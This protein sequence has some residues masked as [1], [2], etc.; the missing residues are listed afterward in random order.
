M[1][2][3]SFF[4][5]VSYEIRILLFIFSAIIKRQLYL[6][7]YQNVLCNVLLSKPMCINLMDINLVSFISFFL[8]VNQKSNLHEFLICKRFLSIIGTVYENLMRQFN[9]MY[10]LFPLIVWHTFCTQFIKHI[11]EKWCRYSN[12]FRI[13]NY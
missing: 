10:I 8:W 4:I 7:S 13:L 11:V 3:V 1:V 6:I 5:C 12:I 9:Y 2:Y